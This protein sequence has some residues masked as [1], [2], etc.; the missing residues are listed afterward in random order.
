MSHHTTAMKQVQLQTQHHH[1]HRR[2]QPQQYSSR[3]SHVVASQNMEK[4]QWRNGSMFNR[5]TSTPFRIASRQN[6]RRSWGGDDGCS[7]WL[8]PT[9]SQA[10][11][12]GRRKSSDRSRGQWDALVNQTKQ[13]ERKRHTDRSIICLSNNHAVY[14]DASFLIIIST[15]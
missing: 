9:T 4:G 13:A 14:R 6:N 10:Y 5:E 15:H 2:H 3:Y 12:E 11:G 7:D 8:G 1:R